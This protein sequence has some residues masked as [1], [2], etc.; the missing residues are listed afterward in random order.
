[1]HAN[2]QHLLYTEML[3]HYTY[4]ELYKTL[5]KVLGAGKNEEKRKRERKEKEG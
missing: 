2:N 3:Q 5:G 1:M 4:T